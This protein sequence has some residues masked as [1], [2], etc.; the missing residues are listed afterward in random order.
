[1]SDIIN[2][3][4]EGGFDLVTMTK[5]IDVLPNMYGRLQAMGVFA[6]KG[7]TQ[8]TVVFEEKNGVLNLLQTQ[9]WGAPAAENKRGKRKMRSFAIPHIPLHDR[10]LPDDFQG[11][12]Q[13]DSA[14]QSVNL[15]EVMSDT[16]T[17]MRSKHDI[18]LEYLR[19]GAIKGTIMDADASVLYNLFTEFGVT[20]LVVDLALDVD[21]TD[22]AAKCRTILR[23]MEDNLKG[24]IMSGC[25]CLCSSTFFDALIG[26]PNVEKFWLNH[27]SALNLSGDDRDPRKGFSFG[28]IMFEE[29]RG[30][31]DDASGTARK[32]IA[33]NE[34]HFFPTGTRSTFTGY[35]APAN[36]LETVNTKGMEIYAKQVMDSA[37][38]WVDVYTESNPLPLCR[39]PSLLVKGT[40]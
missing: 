39:R 11:V 3:F 8:R 37:G 23:H 35:F 33:D 40:I 24:E 34:A 22:V 7:V 38:R 1:M 13:F 29:Y 20:Q 32:F 16:L 15:N 6:F 30:T 4:D 21:A 9:P 25:H 27:S 26:H 12:R 19:M 28:G 10:I 36:Y 17:G 18:T 2:P 31:A 14:D 5:G